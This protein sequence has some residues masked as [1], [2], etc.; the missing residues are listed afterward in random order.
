[1]RLAGGERNAIPE[2]AAIRLN[3]QQSALPDRKARFNADADNAEIVAPDQLVPPDQFVAGQPLLA[4]PVHKLPLV[5][6]DPA[7]SRR[8][9]AIGKLGAALFTGPKG[10]GRFSGRAD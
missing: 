9:F 6:A 1:D 3:N 7:R 8:L 10:H 2:H 4:L 5:L